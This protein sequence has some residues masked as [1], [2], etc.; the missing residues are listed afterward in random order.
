VFVVS[1]ARRARPRPALR[2][3][4]QTP[5]SGLQRR[6]GLASEDVRANPFEAQ[7][8]RRAGAGAVQKRAG[9]LGAVRTEPSDFGGCAIIAQASN[10]TADNRHADELIIHHRAKRKQVSDHRLMMPMVD[11][12]EV[13]R[14]AQLDPGVAQFHCSAFMASDGARIFKRP[15]FIADRV[16]HHAC[17]FVQVRVVEIV[18]YGESAESSAREK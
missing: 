11:R 13:V 8:E 9:V 5:A 4:Y 3:A 17:L 2:L 15:D 10:R 14:L 12:D 7:G 6:S 16:R 18:R 1:T